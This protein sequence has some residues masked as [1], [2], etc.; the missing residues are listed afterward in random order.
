MAKIGIAPGTTSKII[1]VKA[2]LLSTGADLTGV[3]FGDIVAYYCIEGSTPVAIT[4]ASATPGTWTSGGFIQ[5]SA[6]HMP[7]EYELG[8]PN[9]AIASGKSVTVCITANGGTSAGM[10]TIDAEIQMDTSVIVQYPIHKNVAPATAFQF[11]MTL[12]VD[13]VSPYTGAA[14]TIT[15]YVNLDGTKTAISAGALASL[16]QVSGSAGD[17]QITLGA[18]DVNG[19]FVQFRANA[20]GCDTTKIDFATQS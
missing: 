3:V 2:V 20:A 9:A 10:K 4:L 13:H 16:A 11:S 5:R 12:S 18:A 1:V 15:P 17:Y 6:T 8:L 19:N 14:N 7:G